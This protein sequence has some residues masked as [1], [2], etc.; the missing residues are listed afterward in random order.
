MNPEIT[1]TPPPPL[2]NPTHNSAKLELQPLGAPASFVVVIEALLRHPGRIL[3]ECKQRSSKVPLILLVA[4]VLGLAV[5]GALLGTFSGGTQYWASPVK[6]VGG[7]LASL[8]ICLPSLYIFSALGGIEARL[9]QVVG[10][11]LSMM[12]LTALLLLG[13]TPVVWIFSQSTES[14]GFMGFL[15]L[16]FWV[17]ALLFGFRLLVSAA[18]TFGMTGGLYLTIWMGIFLVVTLQMSTALR[19]LIGT[20]TTLLPEKKMFFLEHWIQETGGTANSS[21]NAHYGR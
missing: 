15:V 10:M 3:N 17:I 6:V 20:A 21:G 2:P 19:P 12:A 16:A 5:F 9:P 18:G 8:I 7:V 1:P 4:A 11:L 13:F 14:V